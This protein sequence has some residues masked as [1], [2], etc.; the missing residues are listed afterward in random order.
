[1]GSQAREEFARVLGATCCGRGQRRIDRS[2]KANAKQYARCETIS[3]IQSFITN[4]ADAFG[5]V[6][7]GVITKASVDYVLTLPGGMKSTYDDD[8]LVWEGG[9]FAFSVTGSPYRISF[10]Q[11]TY[12]RSLISDSKDIPNSGDTATMV[13][14]MLNTTYITLTDKYGNPLSAFLQGKC[15]QRK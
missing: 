12:L 7:G 6:L 4:L 11:P 9:L 8:H 14:A 3:D 2:R 1:M 10:F 5:D 15:V 13:N